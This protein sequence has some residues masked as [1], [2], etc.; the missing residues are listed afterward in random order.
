MSSW[1]RPERTDELSELVVAARCVGIMQTMYSC[2]DLAESVLHESISH[3]AAVAP[4]VDAARVTTP[5]KIQKAVLL[6]PPARARCQLAGL[7]GGGQHHAAPVRP[8]ETRRSPAPDGAVDRTEDRE[9]FNWFVG[10]HRFRNVGHLV[11]TASAV[12][13]V[14][15]RRYLLLHRSR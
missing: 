14:V 11:W 13:L 9:V 12:A 2:F 1:A 8:K 5:R 4:S 7:G 3:G 6:C 10:A 15:L